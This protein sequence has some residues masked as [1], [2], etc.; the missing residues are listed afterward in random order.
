MSCRLLTRALVI[1]LVT[2]TSSLAQVAV[3]ANVNGPAA[4]NL[5]ARPSSIAHEE[6]TSGR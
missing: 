3:L 2:A 6:R 5:G 1:V 4:D